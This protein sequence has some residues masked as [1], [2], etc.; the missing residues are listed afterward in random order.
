MSICGGGE[1]IPVI[2]VLGTKGGVGKSLDAREEVLVVEDGVPQFVSIADL[3]NAD[4]EIRAVSFDE[5]L[6]TKLSNVQSLIKHE[7]PSKMYEIKTRTGRRV[8][9]TGDHS[10][11]TLNGLEVSPV[12]ARS[13]KVGNYIAV[14]RKLPSGFHDIQE[15]NI[16]EILKNKDWGLRTDV[17]PVLEAAIRCIGRRRVADILGVKE[18]Y[19]QRILTDFVKKGKPYGIPV[20]NFMKLVSEARIELDLKKV[21][22]SKGQWNCSIPAVIPVTDD[23]ARFLGY[24]V[25][26]GNFDGPAVIITNSNDE[27]IADVKSICRRLFGLEAKCYERVNENSKKINITIMSQPLVKALQLLGVKSG[28]GEKRVPPL[29]FGLSK[30]KIASFLRGYYSGDGSFYRYTIE[31]ATKSEGLASDLLYLLLTFGIVARR[32]ERKTAGRTYHYVGFSSA[33]QLMTFLSEI[34]FIQNEKNRAIGEYIRGRRANPN[35]DVVPNVVDIF[36]DQPLNYSWGGW[37]YHPTIKEHYRTSKNMSRYALRKLAGSTKDEKARCLAESHIFWDKITEV[38]EF[39]YD[40]PWVYDISC[41]PTEN[42]V[43][44]LGGVFLHNSTIAMGIAIWAAKLRPKQWTLL[45]DGDMHVQTIGLKM[46][47]VTDV[48]LAEVLEKNKPV[49][50]AI[51]LCELEMHGKP[52]FDHLAILPA[53][54]RFLPAMRGNP[55]DFINQTK[56]KF[57]GILASLHKRF[58]LV[59]V[60]TP[61][62]MSFEHLILTAIADRIVYVCEPNDDS[63]EATKLTADG[64]KEFMDVQP[65]GV[66]INRMPA[67]VGEKIWVKKASKIAPV[68]G[69]VP[70]DDAVGE[71]FR[72]NL[73][74]VAVA[75]DCQA[76]RAIEKIARQVIETKVRPTELP[77]KLERAL[78][79]TAKGV[80]K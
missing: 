55:L 19:A 5:Q 30:S 37:N 76:S 20:S 71:A 53:G 39:D 60:D 24:F 34:G 51:Y 68:L 15:F 62:S 29:I 17:A 11:F 33:P 64:L 8:R 70:E 25:A 28:A 57:D 12:A 13:L 47:P 46:C 26:E 80:K 44:G 48:T 54:G 52:L 63:I 67:H 58:P 79:E 31:A 38:R 41:N 27:I 74:V 2:S 18:K 56:R 66:V 16:L 73:P 72:E 4:G 49:E 69:V 10:L 1:N 6:Q 77:E 78:R 45:I 32:R 50:E 7:A 75:P 35:I 40:L 3:E 36:A 9:V 42:F 21:R 65:I 43:G 22:L 23:F 59:I 14:P 61:A